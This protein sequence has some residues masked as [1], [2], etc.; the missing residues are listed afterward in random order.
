MLYNIA[1]CD[2]DRAFIQYIKEKICQCD[3]EQNAIT[4]YDFSSGEKLVAK[5]DEMQTCDLLI[6]DMQLPR[7]DGHATAKHFREMYPDSILVFCSG[8]CSPTDESFKTT[9]YRYLQKSYSDEKMLH[10]LG[11]IVR[12]MIATRPAPYITGTNHYNMIKLKP[13]DI[14]YIENYKR[15][16]QIHVCE[17]TKNYTF[18]NKITTQLKLAELYGTL[19]KYGFEYA[20]NSYIVNLN[21]VTK[22][23]SDGVLRMVNGCELNVSRSR[24][25]SFRLALAD[26]MGNK[27]RTG[28]E[29]S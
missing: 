16:S 28:R 19:K 12:K 4:F 18:E 8:V 27:Y 3:W 13:N 22:L 17:K 24:L 21:Y 26:L 15:G 5:M 25:Q 2:D 7:M 14:L 11:E 10:E 23:R 1:I 29:E 6:L 9:P 20:H